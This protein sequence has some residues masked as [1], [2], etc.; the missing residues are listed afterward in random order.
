VKQLSKQDQDR[1]TEELGGRSGW[2][3]SFG[4]SEKKLW[5]YVKEI[6]DNGASKQDLE[7]AEERKR[8]QGLF[9]W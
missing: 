2:C 9:Y 8:K 5:A 4:S 3:S 1:G 7:E 6:R